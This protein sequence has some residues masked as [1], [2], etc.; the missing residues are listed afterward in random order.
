MEFLRVF[1]EEAVAADPPAAALEGSGRVPLCREGALD[2]LFRAAG[3]AEVETHAV[4]M[5]T[6]FSTF[7]DYWTP[8]LRGTG[9]APSYVAS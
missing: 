4:E 6:E 7:E 9:P 5:Q 1:G 2:S 3:V 8:F